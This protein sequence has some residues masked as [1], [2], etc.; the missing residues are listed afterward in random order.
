MKDGFPALGR[1]MGSRRR[2]FTSAVGFGAVGVGAALGSP[3]LA[4]AGTS[5]RPVSWVHGTA[6]T[7]VRDDGA[8]GA[9]GV[10]RDRVEGNARVVQGRSWSTVSLHYAVPMPMLDSGAPLDVRAI[11]VRLRSQ[12]G[13]AITAVTLYDCERTIARLDGLDL[14]RADWDDARIALDP[15]STVMRSPGLTIDCTFADVDRRIAISAIGCEFQ[16]GAWA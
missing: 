7:V 6:A 12:A 9:D 4:R 11:W 5:A 10:E 1:I 2:L 13:A 3:G 14:R 8:A 16:V 15:G